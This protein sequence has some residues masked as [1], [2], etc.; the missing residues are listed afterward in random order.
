[1][2][3]EIFKLCGLEKSEILSRLKKFNG[4]VDFE[5]FEDNLDSRVVLSY[6]GNDEI[7]FGIVKS[8]IYN[9][10]SD[11]VYSFKDTP[12]NYFAAELLKRSSY[13]LS[14][15]ESLT[16]GD[17]CSRLV[18]SP[19]ISGNFFEGIVCY[20]TESKAQRLF[21][22]RE[23]LK[24]EGAVSRKTAHCMVKGL[25]LNPNT[26]LALA[27]TGIAGPKGSEGKEVGLTYIAVGSGDFITVFEHNFLGQRNEI[28][29]KAANMAFFYLIRF[30]QGNI[31][32]L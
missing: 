21:V 13:V 28:R 20:N 26:T 18:E 32:L 15:A 1:M 10:F 19:D 30:L 23:T 4:K 3:K 9:D 25:L 27:T 5:V 16:G 2:F 11:S 29:K 22:D 31:L 12:I 24:K 8:R 14:I 7:D 17:I 6:S